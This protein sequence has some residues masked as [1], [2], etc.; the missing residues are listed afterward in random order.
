M[1]KVNMQVITCEEIA[2]D[3]I[4]MVLKEDYISKAAVPGQFLHM[5]VTGHSLRRPLSIARV[6]RE[7]GTVTVIFK[8]L[9]SGT[10][11]LATYEPGAI[12]N[13][14]GPN[15]NGFEISKER[16]STVLLIGGGVGIPP[17]HFLGQ[18][19]AKQGVSVISVL[20]YQTAS[21]VFY[22]AEF[23][24]FG[25]TIIVTND[26]SAGEKGFVTDHLNHIGY[27][28]RYYSCGPLPMLQAVTT[29]LAD[30]TGYVSLE[31][32]MGCG[33][34]ACYACV[35]RTDDQGGYRK[36]C[37]DGPVFSAQEVQL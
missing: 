21:H 17:L 29:D 13:V 3:T 8:K 27:F 5:S 19:L 34:G 7:L 25:K 10:R 11:K 37:Q 26:G 35:I 16:D 36:I 6:D 22:E 12:V 1:K 31:E 23:N 15:G 4:E 9:G 33:I 32:R 24:Q 2:L 18:S 20:G 28:D 14:L 30:K